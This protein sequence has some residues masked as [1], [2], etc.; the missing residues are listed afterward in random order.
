MIAILGVA[1]YHDVRTREIP[2]HI[3][4]IGGGLGAIL[5]VFDWDD[6]DSFVMYSM[7]LG[8]IIA[9][10]MWRLFPMGEADVLGVL[11][12]SVVYPVSFDVIMIPA[13]IFFGGLILEHLAAFF[14]NVRYNAADMIRTGELYQGVDNSLF[15]KILAFYSVHKKRPHERFAFCAEHTQ[16]G[17]RRINLKTPS[18]NSEYETRTGVF[19]TWAIPAFP[20]MLAAFVSA[21]IYGMLF[22]I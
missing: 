10:V 15:V 16:H 2:D 21:A 12:S 4:I 6:V 22:G 11:V 5:Y 20:F 19:V 8:G 17:R 18:A 9:L 13:V 1:S 14:Y 7:A 3:W